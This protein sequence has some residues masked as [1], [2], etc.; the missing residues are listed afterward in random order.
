MNDKEK[1]LRIF[2][3]LCFETKCNNNKKDSFDCFYQERFLPLKF[4]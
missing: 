4:V 2:R 1:L 3:S